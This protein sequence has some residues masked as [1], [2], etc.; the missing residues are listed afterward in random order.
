[1]V[2]QLSELRE[3]GLLQQKQLE[4]LTGMQDQLGYPIM[5]ATAV[6]D[7][8]GGGSPAKHSLEMLNQKVLYLYNFVVCME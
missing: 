4:Q 1:M 2:E 6:A 8:A 7:G 3:Q 5:A